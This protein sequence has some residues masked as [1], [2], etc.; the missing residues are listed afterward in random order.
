MKRADNATRYRPQTSLF[1]LREIENPSAF[2]KWKTG[3]RKWTRGRKRNGIGVCQFPL[4][5]LPFDECTWTF[6]LPA[7][8][9]IVWLSILDRN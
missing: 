5:S 9:E 6:G 8:E 4:P 2:I 3:K 1:L 7:K